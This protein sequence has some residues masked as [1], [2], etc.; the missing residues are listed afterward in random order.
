VTRH[1]R[2]AEELKSLGASLARL[3]RGG[4]CICLTGE[5]GAGKTTLTQGIAQGLKV[6][7]EVI[8]PTFVLERRYPLEGGELVHIDF[9]RMKE[10]KETDSLGL[11]ESLTDPNSIVVIEWAE[12]F[13][14]ALPDERLEIR[15]KQDGEGR[16]LEFKAIGDRYVELVKQLEAEA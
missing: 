7:Q 16:A 3:L 8:S 9:Y 15:L 2:S 12:K 11:R 14:E 4:E 6:E 5:L 13:P 1:T 10:A